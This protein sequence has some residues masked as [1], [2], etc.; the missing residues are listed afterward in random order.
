MCWLH[1]SI[2]RV[3]SGGAWWRRRGLH[4]LGRVSMCAVSGGVGAGVNPSAVAVS[5]M[6]VCVHACGARVR[7][8]RACARVR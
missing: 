7:A 5:H 1:V 4:A 8:P 2:V 3:V 6:C